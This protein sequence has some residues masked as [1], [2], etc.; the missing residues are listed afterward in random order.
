MTTVS[1]FAQVPHLQLSS[2]SPLYC[3]QHGVMVG[4][5]PAGERREFQKEESEICS[6]LAKEIVNFL[7]WE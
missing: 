3:P 2:F 7:I 6:F 5:V 1:S 4:D